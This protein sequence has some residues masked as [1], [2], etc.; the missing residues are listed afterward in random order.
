MPVA[1]GAPAPGAGPGPSCRVR[2]RRR[3]DRGLSKPHELKSRATANS[4]RGRRR[5]GEATGAAWRA[6]SAP[7]VMTL[8]DRA[9][10]RRELGMTPI[11]VDPGL[12]TGMRTPR[13]DPG[14]RRSNPRYPGRN[15][16]PTQVVDPVKRGMTRAKLER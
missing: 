9:A 11:P 4:D 3:A 16:G 8:G 10:G 14:Q 5:R 13:S 15:S 6:R 12:A 2:R 1:R 7:I